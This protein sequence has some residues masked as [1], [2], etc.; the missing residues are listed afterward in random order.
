MPPTNTHVAPIEARSAEPSGGSAGRGK[1]T[2]LPRDAQP[3]AIMARI[4][5]LITDYYPEARRLAAEAAARFPDHDEIRSA[6][7][8]LNSPAGPVGTAPPEPPTDEEFEWLRNPPESVRG[9]WVALS[10]REMVATADK[11]VD[12][13]KTLRSQNPRKRALVH[14][15]E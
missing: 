4:R 8:V 7:Y 6:H 1:A 3:E 9:K 14:R 13:V 11:L 10:G 2:L 5:A 12:L 15:I